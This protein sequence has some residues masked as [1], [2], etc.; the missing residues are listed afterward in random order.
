MNVLDA[1]RNRRSV[2]AYAPRAIPDDVMQR[3]REALRVAPSA[4]NLQPWHFV[5]VTDAALRRSLGQ[6]A[7]GQF[8]IA[9]APV[10]VVACGLPQQAYP[11]MGGSG[12]SVDIDVTI[13]LDH[14]M[15]AA[16]AEGLGTCWIGSF[17]EAEVKRLLDIPRAVKVVALTPLGYP[18]SSDLI[19]PVLDAQRKGPAEIFSHDRF[20]QPLP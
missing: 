10:V 7:H 9:S 5:F 14:L 16:V 4:C 18:A 17:S 15:L 8:W 2:R 20:S 1:I 13:A 12:N 19:Y 6:A 3:M 11:R